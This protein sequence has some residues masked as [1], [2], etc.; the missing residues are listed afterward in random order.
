MFPNRR[1]LAITR[2][3]R[4]QDFR[5][6]GREQRALAGLLRL[7]TTL[8]TVLFFPPLA[9]S[10]ERETAQNMLNLISQAQIKYCGEVEPEIPPESPMRESSS[11]NDDV[12]C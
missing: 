2:P 10:E 7:E 6:R 12:P 8:K 4:R 1:E 9:T 5:Q 3:G 11:E